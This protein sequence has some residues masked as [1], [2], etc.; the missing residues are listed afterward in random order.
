MTM[1]TEPSRIWRRNR[2]F[3]VLPVSPVGL[4][5]GALC[6]GSFIH[7]IISDRIIPNNQV[8]PWCHYHRAELCFRSPGAIFL[9]NEKRKPVQLWNRLYVRTGGYLLHR[10]GDRPGYRCIHGCSRL[11]YGFRPLQAMVSGCRVRA[12]WILLFQTLHQENK[13]CLRGGFQGSKSVENNLLVRGIFFS[14]RIDL[15]TG[16]P[17]DIRMS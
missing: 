2:S 11:V 5:P 14:D 1:S 7:I 4:I 3:P 13:L 17:Q 8:R 9:L 10:A 15:P 12:A 16:A 6:S